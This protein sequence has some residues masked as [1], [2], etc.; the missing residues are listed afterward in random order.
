[1]PSDWT[2]EEATSLLNAGSTHEQLAKRYGY[3]SHS[4]FTRRYNRLLQSKEQ[5][6]KLQYISK[7]NDP[8]S[9][10]GN[11]ISEDK[12]LGQIR[13]TQYGIIPPTFKRIEIDTLDQLVEWI[14]TY[15]PYMQDEWNNANTR[16]NASTLFFDVFR[17]G[18]STLL[19][20]PRDSGKSKIS[21]AV[22]AC[23]LANYYLPQLAI[24]NGS[25][26]K[27]RIF[28][29]LWRILRSPK[30]R[31]DYGDILQSKDKTLGEMI[32]HED[33]IEIQ[34]RFFVSDDP[35]FM[36]CAYS[37]I[38]GAHPF[39][40]WLE[41]ILQSEYKSS[42]SN[43]FMLYEVYDAI[44]EKLADRIGGTFTRKGRKDLYSNL[45][46]R[47]VLLR[48]CSA[49]TK[50][51]GMWPTVDDLIY[52]D[53]GRMV[54]VHIDPDSEFE[55][56]DR[57][58][59]TVESLLLMRTRSLLDRKAYIQFEREM[60][61]NPLAIEGLYFK[62]EWWTEIKSYDYSK[63]TKYLIADTAF[64][65][66]ENADY[67]CIGVWIYTGEKNPYLLLVDMILKQNLEFDAICREIV[68]MA[69]KHNVAKSYVHAVMRETWVLQRLRKLMPGVQLAEEKRNKIERIN[70]L[71]TPFSQ[72]DIRI[73]SEIPKRYLQEA[74]D[75]FVEYDQTDSDDTR[76]DDFLDM[77]ATAYEK[78]RYLL[79]GGKRAKFESYV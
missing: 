8:V 57:P 56:I 4:G 29:G 52:D 62:H 16:E 70:V 39:V 12:S 9:I 73:I 74:Y 19:G 14:Q 46:S 44:I 51:T 47:N 10:E 71:D 78:L 25:K 35:S 27:R 36:V 6:V 49:I 15:T 37:G 1:M 66:K 76:K 55:I 3:A 31:M 50:I 22:Y 72:G 32:L 33:L 77:C 60:Q 59:W 11:H 41:D 42:E 61:N 67:N 24:V 69:T 79:Y 38:I 2:F 43:E 21:V 26:A 34:N 23:I 40:V 65:M 53:E 20:K 64:G 48:V 68:D 63:H 17:N 13:R 58:G 30:F 18:K 5:A 54:G 75:Q 45:P 7:K 28:N